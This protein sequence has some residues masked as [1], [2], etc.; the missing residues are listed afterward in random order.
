VYQAMYSTTALRAAARPGQGLVSM[1][2]PLSELKND[3]ATVLSQHWPLRPTGK[4]M[5]R[6]PTSVANAVEVY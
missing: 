4:M 2:S 5:S 1:S 6:S 3:S